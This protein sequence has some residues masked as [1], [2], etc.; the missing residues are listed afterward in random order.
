MADRHFEVVFL[1]LADGV[2]VLGKGSASTMRLFRLLCRFTPG[3][4]GF[5]PAAFSFVQRQ[6]Y[7]HSENS[8]T[9]K[10]TYSRRAARGAMP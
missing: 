5:S 6:P 7:R 3:F 9:V 4:H 8:S 1:R 2:R 10:K